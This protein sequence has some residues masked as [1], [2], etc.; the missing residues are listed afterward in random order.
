MEDDVWR[1]R[2]RWRRKKKGGNLMVLRNFDEKRLLY[3]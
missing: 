1:W 2:E 3:H